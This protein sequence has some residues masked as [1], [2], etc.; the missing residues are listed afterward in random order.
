M[1]NDAAMGP[2]PQYPIESVGNA[3]RLLLMFRDRSPLRLAEVREELGVAH[4][5]AHRLMAMLVHYGF[6][7]QDPNTRLYVAGPAL[8]EIGLM[9]VQRMDI[10][11]V[12]RPILEEVAAEV[13]ETVHLGILE[14]GN[15][16]FIDAIESEL[17]LRVSGRIGQLMPAYGTSIGKV[18]LAELPTSV[19]RTIYRNESL[20]PLTTNTITRRSVLETELQAVRER[21]YAHNDGESEDG[22][23][24]VGVAIRNASGGLVG[25]LSIAA[26][27]IRMSQI[28]VER[29]AGVLLRA[30][31]QLSGSVAALGAPGSVQRQ[32]GRA[33][34]DAAG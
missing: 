3:L 7:I 32:G 27:T 2:V 13:G 8:V 26:P 25:A 18:M 9:S 4:S 20:Q 15:V 21:G 5:T 23:A 30:S 6:V 29:F 12:A 31:E 24:S 34:A 28:Q 16:R 14:G 1:Q 19:I 17:A 22:V 11:T 10:R 33:T